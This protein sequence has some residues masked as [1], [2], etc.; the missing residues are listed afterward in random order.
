MCEA[1]VITSI[2]EINEEALK[3]LTDGK[4]DEDDE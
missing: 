1:E 2:D 4:G 3:E